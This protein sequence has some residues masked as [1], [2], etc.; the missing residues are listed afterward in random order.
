MAV[1]QPDLLLLSLPKTALQ[2]RYWE[3]ADLRVEIVSDDKPERRPV[4]SA[5]YAEARV[6]E[7]WIID[8]ARKRLPSSISLKTP[9]SKL[10]S[11]DAVTWPPRCF[12]PSFQSL[13]MSCSTRYERLNVQGDLLAPDKVLITD[14]VAVRVA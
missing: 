7:Y 2:S 4:E 1:S 6:P 10:A 8:R 12:S 3:G 9:M 5:H 11:T 14:A 13:W